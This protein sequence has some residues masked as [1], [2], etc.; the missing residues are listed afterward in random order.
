MTDHR[1]TDLSYGHLGEASYDVDEQSWYFSSQ[2]SLG[3]FRQVE[4]T[5]QY[6]QFLQSPPYSL[7]NPYESIYLLLCEFLQARPRQLQESVNRK[8]DGFEKP[9][10]TPVLRKLLSH[11]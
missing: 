2:T 7:C 3:K 6:L 11:L 1:V 9:C 10:L 5:D 8:K 4:F